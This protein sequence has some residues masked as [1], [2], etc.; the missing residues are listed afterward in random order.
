MD[1]TTLSSNPMN[2]LLQHP[3]T[4]EPFSSYIKVIADQTKTLT[5]HNGG[6]ATAWITYE[7]TRLTFDDVASSNTFA[8]IILQANGT[9][10][11]STQDSKASPVGSILDLTFSTAKNPPE[12]SSNEVGLITAGS[13]S[14][15]MQISGY[16]V[17][18][19]SM[20]RTIEFGTATV[21]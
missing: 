19:K 12:T 7:G 13:Y 17:D 9:N 20:T 18:G 3:K 1:D 14:M 2:S 16:D 4:V 5:V 15:K 10:V 6:P 21:I 11:N 8:A